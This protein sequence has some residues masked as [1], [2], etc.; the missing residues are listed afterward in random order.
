MLCGGKDAENVGTG[1][2]IGSKVGDGGVIQSSLCAGQTALNML[3]DRKSQVYAPLRSRENR[4]TARR[5]HKVLCRALVVVVTRNDDSFR[6]I[7]ASSVG[8]LQWKIMP[9]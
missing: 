9:F 5:L 7:C 6:W 8:L 3:F 2:R 4:E 1:W